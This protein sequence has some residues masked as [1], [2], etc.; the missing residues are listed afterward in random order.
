MKGKYDS[1]L[2]SPNDFTVLLGVHNVLKINETGTV[3]ARVRAIH[4]HPDWNVNVNSYEADIAVIVL[5]N[6]IQFNE[7]IHPICLALPQ[8]APAYASN[9]TV[10]GFGRT[11]TREYS[12]IPQKL[13][14]PISNY[15]TCTRKSSRHRDLVGSRSFC[16]GPAGGRGVCDGDSGSGLYVLHNEK[17]YLRGIVSASLMTNVNECNVDSYAMFTDA[18]KFYEWMKSIGPNTIVENLNMNLQPTTESAIIPATTATSASTTTFRT[19]VLQTTTKSSHRSTYKLTSSGL[20]I[21]NR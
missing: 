11:E 5:E 8:S 21:W 6:E 1:Y 17:F 20:P 2:F 12:K 10:V 7:F 18:P 14:L 13:D 4:I 16:G 15:H 3:S 9:G 19:Q